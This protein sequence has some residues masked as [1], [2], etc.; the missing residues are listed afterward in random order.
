MSYPASLPPVSEGQRSRYDERVRN[1]HAAEASPPGPTL[2]LG[3]SAGPALDEAAAAAEWNATALPLLDTAV[4]VCRTQHASWTGTLATVT[5]A[6]PTIAR[7]LLDPGVPGRLATLEGAGDDFDRVQAAQK[8][9]PTVAGFHATRAAHDR[10]QQA[11][12]DPELVAAFGPT[13]ALSTIVATFAGLP[14]D[15]RT[16]IEGSGAPIIRLLTRLPIAEVGGLGTIPA[17]VIDRFVAKTTGEVRA[18]IANRVS[19]PAEATQ[20]RAAFTTQL[21][22]LPTMADLPETMCADAGRQLHDKFKGKVDAARQD[23]LARRRELLAQ[24]GGLDDAKVPRCTQLWFVSPAEAAAFTA[25]V[26]AAA[27]APARFKSNV[28]TAAG[29]LQAT[30]VGGNHCCY[31]Y[32]SKHLSL[33]GGA[34]QGPKLDQIL[35]DLAANVPG[36]TVN[37]PMAALLNTAYYLFTGLGQSSVT[38][39]GPS[40]GAGVLVTVRHDPAATS[41]WMTHLRTLRGLALA[42]RHTHVTVRVFHGTTDP[43]LHTTDPAKLGAEGSKHADPDRKRGARTLSGAAKGYEYEIPGLSGSRLIEIP[44]GDATWADA[45]WYVSLEHYH[46]YKLITNL[47]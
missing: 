3:A 20:C 7:L 34:D 15:V 46:S 35:T 39:P 18:A 9:T 16:A 23:G 37:A 5:G 31:W 32:L 4:G 22:S 2:H 38:Q 14:A 1:R 36:W 41:A 44:R 17:A 45:N 40:R 26:N 12:A 19:A 28:I 27:I 25:R 8:A 24:T 43:N 13:S 21:S 33:A 42:Q 30:P 11:A 47:P 10:V 6:V 29:L